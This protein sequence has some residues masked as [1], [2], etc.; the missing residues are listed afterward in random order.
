MVGNVASS[1]FKPLALLS[2]DP[3]DDYSQ[4]KEKKWSELDAI[5]QVVKVN[6]GSKFG[7][8]VSFHTA[9]LQS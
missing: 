2:G 8:L 3:R 7:F 5:F 1:K 9:I 6:F 4:K